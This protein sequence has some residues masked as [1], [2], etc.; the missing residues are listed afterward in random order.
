MRICPCGFRL[1]NWLKTR[2]Q[3]V[4]CDAL[5]PN[6]FSAPRLAFHPFLQKKIILVSH[7]VPSTC[8]PVGQAFAFDFLQAIQR[9][10]AVCHFAAVVAM[11][12]LGQVERQVLF[13]DVMECPHDSAFQEREKSLDSVCVRQSANVFTRRMFHG[14]MRCKIFRRAAIGVKII[15]HN[16]CRLLDVG[17]QNFLEIFAG[18]VLHHLRT[19]FAVALN[20]RN[21][22][23]FVAHEV[24]ALSACLAADI[25]F[26]AL[27]RAGK[28]VAERR[29]F[30]R[31]TDSVR[32]K[33]CRA[34]T[35]KFQVA[36]Q[37]ERANS[38]FGTANEIPSNEPFAERDFAGLKNCAYGNGELLF[39][40]GTPAQSGTDF[41]VRV[42]RYCRK[43]GLVRAFAMR[44]KNAVFPADAFK[45]FAGGFVSRKLVNYFY[46][47]QVF[48]L[49]LSHASNIAQSQLFVKCIIPNTFYTITGKREDVRIL[50]TIIQ[51]T[52]ED[53]NKN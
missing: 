20:Q 50:K 46:Q 53:Y 7:F 9:A 48:G 33:K 12:K 14:L 30:K 21:D 13:A 2:R 37:L 5:F 39:A 1:F 11:V 29:V 43:L 45:M 51:Q 3:K 27:N 24:T 28:F 31:K 36:L 4:N 52:I 34:V 6:P 18:D 47:C 8:V 10:L 22:G 19:H 42:S 32:H 49:F 41:R 26:I 16:R 44:A 17:F 40:V 15:R 38:F 35:A 25:R 23:N